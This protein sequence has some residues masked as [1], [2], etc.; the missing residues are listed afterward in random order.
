MLA[1]LGGSTSESGGEDSAER[2]SADHASGQSPRAEA[3]TNGGS[4]CAWCWRRGRAHTFL[5]KPLIPTRVSLG[6]HTSWRGGAHVNR[7]L[8]SGPHRGHRQLKQECRRRSESIQG[9]VAP[10]RA[11]FGRD[12]ATATK[13]ASR[14]C[15]GVGPKPLW[16]H[17]VLRR[18]PT[19]GSLVEGGAF[20]QWFRPGPRAWTRRDLRCS[21]VIPA[22]QRT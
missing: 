9:G 14:P 6:R 7:P 5:P 13:V 2:S 16:E 1:A 12:D 10:L 3:D 4:R 8:M 19:R 15:M 18:S 22:E 20:P 11:L 21:R 17:P